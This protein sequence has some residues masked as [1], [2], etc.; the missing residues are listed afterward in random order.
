[1]TSSSSDHDSAED[2]PMR[3]TDHANRTASV[4][5]STMT[6]K[7]SNPGGNVTASDAKLEN[8]NSEFSFFTQD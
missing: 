8:V 3:G 6:Q 1:M 4:H 2:G 5:A 7:S